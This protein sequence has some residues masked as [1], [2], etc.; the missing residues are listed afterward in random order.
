MT[1]DEHPADS[2][3]DAGQYAT[4]F[5]EMPCFVTVQ[6]RDLRLVET[7]RFFEERFGNRRGAACWEV[8]KQRATPCRDCPVDKT[9]TS[10]KGQ[11]AQETVVTPAGVEIPIMVY[12]TPILDGAGGVVRVLHIAADITKVR[13]LQKRLHQTQQKSRQLFDEAPCYITVQDRDLR[14]TAS[15]RRFKDDFGDDL[16]LHCYEVYKHREEPCIECPVMQTFSDG[17]PHTSEEVVTSISGEQ[18]NVLVNTAPIRSGDGEI[19]EVMEMST[20]I[21]EIRR[22]E[23]QLTSLGLLIGSVSH[24]VKGLLTAIDGGMYL[25][26]S[27][28]PRNNQERVQEGWAIV[29]RN[30]RRIR[31][32]V[33]DL[34]YYAK[35]RELDAEPINALELGADVWNM[36]TYRAEDLGIEFDRDFD[37][38]AGE[39]EAD[40]AALRTA[41]INIL[42]NAFDAC[43]V[44]RKKDRHR[45]TFSVIGCDEARVSFEVRDNGIG[46]DRETL[47]KMFT[48]FFSSKGAEGT[49]LGMFVSNKIVRQHGGHI[50]VESRPEEGT[51]IRIVMPRVPLFAPEPGDADSTPR[52][53]PRGG[54]G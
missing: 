23:S 25:V 1:A 12:T 9:F 48:L 13:R 34:L 6:D 42:E 46:M 40:R 54:A 38:A 50:D 21:T 3:T 17:L 10:G 39:L 47:E 31:S 24:G 51:S 27:G 45:V 16:G 22:L 41:L 26:N 30:M 4:Y 14:L 35:D 7:N 29:Q 33:L 37:I 43:R 2:T 19:V 15:N 18:Y 5:R 52:L 28:F 11:E 36:V 8:C 53:D 49:G 44:D 32:M 20:N